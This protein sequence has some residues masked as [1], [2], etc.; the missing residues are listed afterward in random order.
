[1]SSNFFSVDDSEI[2]REACYL[3]FSACFIAG[4]LVHTKEGLAPIEKLKVGDLV[5]SKPEKD[6]GERA[7]KRVVK[8]FVHHDKAIM[9]LVYLDGKEPDLNKAKRYSL[10]STY[11]HPF[12]AE[13]EGWTAA[14]RLKGDWQGPSRLRLADGSNVSLEGPVYIYSTD[15]PQI[16]WVASNGKHDVGTLWNYVNSSIVE[17]DVIYDWES[18]APGESDDNLYDPFKATVYNIEVEDYHTYFVGEF[19]VWV[20]N[21]NCS[22]ILNISS[23]KP[24]PAVKWDAPPRS[25]APRPLPLRW[26]TQNILAIPLILATFL[27]FHFKMV[28]RYGISEPL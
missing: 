22:Y 5:L 24:N 27:F 1:M 17:K 6:D 9:Q 2:T 15:Q 26:A 11:D 4:T 18:W 16:G 20:H 19:G 21:A 13:G 25:A 7:Y 10:T 28:R 14:G 8:T 3:R 12:W 23:L